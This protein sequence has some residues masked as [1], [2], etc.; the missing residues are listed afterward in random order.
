MKPYFKCN[1]F[2]AFAGRLGNPAA[3]PMRDMRAL[4]VDY[5]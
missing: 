3:P 2:V 5:S 1:R 4:V